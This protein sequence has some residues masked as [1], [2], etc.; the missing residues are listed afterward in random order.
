MGTRH[1]IAIYHLREDCSLAEG[2]EMVE[3]A[4]QDAKTFAK[5]YRM[6]RI[7][8]ACRKAVQRSQ[9]VTGT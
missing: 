7:C 8:L 3:V 2:E 9:R 4:D 1:G 6:R 5:K